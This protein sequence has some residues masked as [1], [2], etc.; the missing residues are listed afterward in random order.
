MVRIKSEVIKSSSL[1]ILAVPA[2]GR[3]L[4]SAAFCMRG[5]GGFPWCCEIVP[6]ESQLILPSSPSSLISLRNVA[7]A[8]GERQMFPQQTNKTCIHN[9]MSTELRQDNG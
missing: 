6:A 1:T 7:S 3:L 8:A 2:I 5:S 4:A 9:V